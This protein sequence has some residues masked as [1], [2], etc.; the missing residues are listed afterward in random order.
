MSVSLSPTQLS[1]PYHSNHE[2]Y[3]L[4]QDRGER[5]YEKIIKQEPFELTDGSSATIDISSSGIEFL[6]TKQY[7]QLGG[8]KKL[9]QTQDG[10]LIS[11]SQFSKTKE[12][13]SGTGIGA[14]TKNTALQEST[15]CVFNALYH[16][17]GREI[18]PQDI[19]YTAISESYQY[20]NTTT[21]LD[22]VYSFSQTPTWTQS[23]ITSSN[24]LY[25]Y[26]SGSSYTH[27]RDSEYIE[28]IY[29][30]AK[31]TVNY[32]L[33]KWNPSD[34]WFVKDHVLSTVFSSSLDEL[35]T[36]LEDMF[37]K[38]DLIGVSL[39][40]IGKEPKLEV[41]N[42]KNTNKKQYKYL[43]YK[44]TG[45]SKDI[46][47]LYDGGKICFRTFNYATNWAG[48]I[49]GKTA[50]HGKIGFGAI[51]SILKKHNLE[52][53]PAKE[54]KLLWEERPYIAMS[55]FLTLY[56]EYIEDV[57]GD[58][59]NIFIQDKNIDWK[60]SKLLGL[61]L[62]CKIQNQPQEIQNKILTE[63]LNYASSELE[64]SSIFLKLS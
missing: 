42:S 52:I 57:D 21:T 23:F 41:K 33:D 6:K 27:H 20:V 25:S 4:Y 53:N 55:A 43:G 1:K 59:L 44:T 29:N 47:L 30:S 16:I 40:K 7:N 34:I 14:G 54:I 31:K 48:E 28:S 56:R 12:F 15:Q 50:S 45:K 62:V 64:E 3:G 49:S 24:I 63:F 11:L 10:I 51:N 36:Q 37:T 8:G 32:Q 22:E 2:F 39:K 19:T 26:T 18:N 9:F 58:Q 38:K 60:T 46:S 5:F 61:Q 35:N 13:G 17:Q